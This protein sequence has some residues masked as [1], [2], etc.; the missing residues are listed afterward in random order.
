MSCEDGRTASGIG[1][2]VGV[3]Y[4]GLY[5]IP[6]N[7]LQV[8][9]LVANG[10]FAE[11]V[12]DLKRDW[13][14]YYDVDRGA[15]FRLRASSN[16]DPERVA[17]IKGMVEQMAIS[18]D[19]TH[20]LVITKADVTGPT[21]ASMID[22]RGPTISK[23][24]N[25]GHSVGA[26]PVWLDGNRVLLAGLGQDPSNP[27]K[28][29]VFV[30]DVVTKSLEETVVPEPVKALA[31]SGQ[32]LATYKDGVYHLYSYPELQVVGSVEES[33]L[34]GEYTSQEV[35]YVGSSQLAIPRM[36]G[37]KSS[38]GVVL[39]DVSTGQAQ[40]I[41]DMPLSGMQYCPAEQ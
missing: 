9:K 19:G 2:I 3:H 29:R 4:T 24:W 40:V 13:V 38:L 10:G 7:T 21:L 41:C 15:V 37:P 16:G 34:P 32:R 5:I 36:N 27:G 30:L 23:E 17:P 26:Q 14:Y 11:P 25:L 1:C 35:C 28:G 8:K 18:R 31:S 33:S 12:A 22:L 6:M 20:L 39:V